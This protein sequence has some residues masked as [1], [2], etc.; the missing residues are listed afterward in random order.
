MKKTIWVSY[1]LGI[2]GDYDNLFAWFDD[3]NAKECGDNLAVLKVEI[4]QLDTIK[5]EIKKELDNISFGK[6]DRI[7]IIWR[8]SKKVKGSFIIGKRRLPPWTGYG[9]SDDMND[10]DEDD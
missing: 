2:K 3:N 9:F 10:S 8:E 1:D 5:E 6:R 7:Y 4:K